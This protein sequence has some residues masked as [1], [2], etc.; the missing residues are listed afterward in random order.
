[1]KVSYYCQH[2][3]GVG[4]LHRSLEICRAL[5]K[6]FQVEM[7][8]GG[9]ES[10]LDAPGVQ[11]HQLPGLR[12]DRTFSGLETCDPAASLET[13]KAQR[14]QQLLDHITQNRPDIVV[15]ELYP[16][17]RKQFRFELD[18]LLE[19]LSSDSPHTLIYCSLRDILVEKSEGQ[20]KFE[21][22]AVHTF[23]RF[24]DGLLVH[25]DPQIVTIDET[26]TKSDQLKPE[27]FYTGFVTPHPSPQRANE[28]RRITG[29]N[30]QKKLIVASIGSGS[31]G[32]ELLFSVAQVHALLS[33]EGVV[34]QIFT[35]PYL[36]QAD[37][38]RLKTM[39]S[40]SL[41]IDRFTPHFI[42]WLLAADLSISMA[43][44]N[45]TM[46]VLAA[47]TPALMLPFAQNREQQMRLERLVPLSGI[48]PLT[49]EQLE[50]TQLHEIIEQRLNDERYKSEVNLDGAEN[51]RDYL[52]KKLR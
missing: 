34:T 39:T 4:H 13:V 42:D 16:F 31:V 29:T 44:Y 37:F 9:P 8:L 47:R 15:L 46:N 35:G 7:I 19:W 18:P 52:I 49:R 23:N 11:F 33:E 24:F 3:L 40:D 5:G 43:G 26:F 6:R 32:E 51:T 41:R 17:G 50:P 45:T 28:I 25:A 2:V 30:Q 36:D 38:N 14:Q 27:I 21:T 48:S 20:D 10:N 12:M 1:M 22:R